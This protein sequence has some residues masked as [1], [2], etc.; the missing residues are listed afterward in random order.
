MSLLIDEIAEMVADGLQAADVAYELTLTRITPGEVDEDAPWVPVPPDV[1]ETF[2][3]M[4]WEEEWSAFYLA[5]DLVQSGS[6]KVCILV[7]TLA[8]EPQLGDEIIVRGLTYTIV[9]PSKTDP[10]RAVWEIEAKQG[11][12]GPLDEVSS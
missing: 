8:V 12:A 2:D 10:A 3:C 11:S 5:N 7:P 4:G 9:G 1:V 6:K